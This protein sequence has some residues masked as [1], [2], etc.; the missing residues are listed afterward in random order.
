MERKARLLVSR[1]ESNLIDDGSTGSCFW[2]KPGQKPGFHPILLVKEGLAFV[3][4]KYGLKVFKRINQVSLHE[5]EVYNKHRQ[6]NMWVVDTLAITP[7]K[8]RQGLGSQL[9]LD[10]L[11]FIK[12]RGEQVFVLTHNPENIPY[13]KALGFSL[14]D[15]MPVGQSDVIGY[16]FIFK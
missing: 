7:H 6:K 10:K 1:L 11:K 14:V 8:Q 16:C 12:N 3:P 9:L 4:I 2:F 13:Y 5:I 15:E